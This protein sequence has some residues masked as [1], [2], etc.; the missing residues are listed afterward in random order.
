VSEA[1][2]KMLARLGGNYIRPFDMLEV[3][4]SHIILKACTQVASVRGFE[5]TL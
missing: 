4:E 3:A 2:F 5:I 1:V